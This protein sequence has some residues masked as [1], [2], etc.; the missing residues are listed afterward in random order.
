METINLLLVLF[1]ISLGLIFVLGLWLG[2][3]IVTLRWE[4]N[5]NTIRCLGQYKVIDTN[6]YCQGKVWDNYGDYLNRRG[7]SNEI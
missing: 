5:V 7:I 4:G 6:F 1:P 3:K 2:I